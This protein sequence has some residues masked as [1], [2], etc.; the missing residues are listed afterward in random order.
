MTL[1]ASQ[2]VNN[3]KRSFNKYMAEGLAPAVV[4]FDEGD[5]DASGL[6]IW[7]TIRYR[8]LRSESAGMGDLIEED[9]LQQGRLHILGCGISAW[10]RN[11]L[12]KYGLGGMADKV[13]ALAEA[14]SVTLYDFDD[15]EIP[16]DIGEMKIRPG[17]GVFT[18]VGGGE[19]PVSSS[20]SEVY[21]E[22]GIAGFVFELELVTVA[23][24]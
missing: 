7:Y 1:D 6:A 15:P 19:A 10:S 16:V 14:V 20:E 17:D 18:P 2:M 12:Q 3:M 4:N 22:E 9:S 8:K 13:I 24:I 11:D 23:K 21:S 5:F